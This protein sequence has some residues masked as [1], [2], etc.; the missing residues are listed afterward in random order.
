[1]K[2]RRFIRN[3]GLILGAGAIDL[4]IFERNAPKADKPVVISTWNFGLEVNK[5]AWKILQSGG[6]A[7]DAV[8]SGAWV[9]ESDIT[10][11]SVGRGGS[12][13]RDGIVTLD[14]S[15]MDHLGNAGSVAAI[16]NIE[17]P[18]SVARLVME[19]T[20]HVMLVGDG[21]RRFAIENG[22]PEVDL[23]TEQSRKNYLEWLKT[24]RYKPV[25][26]IENHDTLGILA[27][28]SRGNLSGACTTSGLAYKMHG[29]V[30]DSPV[31]G[32]G[33]YVDN[34]YGA[35]VCT[36]LGEVML[37]NLSSFLVVEMMRNRKSPQKAC[38]IAIE[39]LISKTPGYG[40]LQV[41]IVAL[42]KKGEYGAY[43]IH[44][45]FTFALRTQDT[46]KIFDAPFKYQLPPR[47]EH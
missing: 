10:N 3:S 38:Q 1:M 25:I 34:D 43:A 29:R 46:E 12:P 36:G 23:M 21:A 41:G 22:F 16:E 42:N 27:L 17:H 8:E 35:A 24:S 40:D 47:T 37:K 4:D 32:A 15:I 5:P 13:D 44:N 19:K 30:G 33:L 2:R 45:G 9:A 39:R 26:N 18:V 11:S 14:A 7:L 6:S 28:D 20:P 31:I